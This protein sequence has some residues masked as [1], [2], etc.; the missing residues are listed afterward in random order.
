MY[1]PWPVTAYR[2]AVPHN[3]YALSCNVACTYEADFWG[4]AIIGYGP[5]K[6]RAVPPPY[7]T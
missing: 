7:G 3:V 4:I 6:L 5:D 1:P 2:F